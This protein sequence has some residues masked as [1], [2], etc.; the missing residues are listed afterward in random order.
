MAERGF[1][2][3]SAILFSVLILF[4]GVISVVI[5]LPAPFNVVGKEPL[6]DL[7]IND[8]E[9]VLIHN[10]EGGGNGEFTLFV[11]VP[12]TAILE[13][14]KI[15]P[16]K[17]AIFRDVPP[18]QSMWAEGKLRVIT[19]HQDPK[20]DAVSVGYLEIHIR[21]EKDLEGAGWERSFYNSGAKRQET[22][23]WSTH[24]LCCD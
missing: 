12:G 5:F 17:F 9:R 14:I 8:V 13:P 16:E 18:G 3:F 24:V 1:N 20:Y 19:R 23:H 21:S 2:V 6:G 11:E 7:R 10:L 22:H 15:R 4:A